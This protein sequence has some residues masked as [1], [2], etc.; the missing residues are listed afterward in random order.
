MFSGIEF[1]LTRWVLGTD[2]F[3]LGLAQKGTKEGDEVGKEPVLKRY[4]HVYVY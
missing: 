2:N 1:L 4:V 3:Y